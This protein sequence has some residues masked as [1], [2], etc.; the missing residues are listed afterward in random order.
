MAAF[1]VFFIFFPLSNATGLRSFRKR[2]ATRKWL[3]LF[4]D[5]VHYPL[6]MMAVGFHCIS[7]SKEHLDWRQ[8]EIQTVANSQ[9]IPHSNIQENILRDPTR[10]IPKMCFPFSALSG[11]FACPTFYRCEWINS[12][13]S[14]SFF[15][16]F[17]DLPKLRNFFRGGQ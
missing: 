4:T 15:F 13:H 3:L 5:K 14:K 16:L 11:S 8:W 1:P 17:S 7:K 2:F 9:I 12:C 6:L 10:T